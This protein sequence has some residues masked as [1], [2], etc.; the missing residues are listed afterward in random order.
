MAS[1]EKNVSQCGNSKYRISGY[2]ISSDYCSLINNISAP[3]KIKYPRNFL[4]GRAITSCSICKYVN[5]W[6]RKFP[7]RSIFIHSLSQN[8]LY[9]GFFFLFLKYWKQNFYFTLNQKLE[10]ISQVYYL[11]YGQTRKL[12]HLELMRFI[13]EKGN[14]KMHS[15]KI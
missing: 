4:L 1:I 13:S 3:L 2:L 10:D 15:R 5:C 14:E 11:T 9:L 8:N 7:K 12:I 6:V